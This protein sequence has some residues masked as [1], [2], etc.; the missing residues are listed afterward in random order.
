[1]LK[2]AVMVKLEASLLDLW[3][4]TDHRKLRTELSQGPSKRPWARFPLDFLKKH[5]NQDAYLSALEKALNE[6]LLK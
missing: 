4:T 3:D 2:G 5:M 6:Y 1:K